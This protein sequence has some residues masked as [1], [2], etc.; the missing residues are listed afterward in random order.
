MVVV[1]EFEYDSGCGCGGA[2]GRMTEETRH[3]DS[4]TTRV[5]EH[6]YDWRGR[7]VTIDGEL[8]YFEKRYYDNLDRVVRVERYDTTEQGNLI[9]RS[10][11]FHDDLGR[12]YQTKR[13]AVD[14]DDGTV[15]N[16]LVSNT[17]YDAVGNAIKQQSAGSQA[18]TKTAYDSL[19]RSVKQYVVYDTD[20]TAYADASS[21]SDDTIVEQEETVYDDTN[22]VL[23]T[24]KRQR[25]HN[26][27]GTGEL[28]SPSGSQPKARVTYQASY[29]DEVGRQIAVAEY[30]T[31]GGAAF[32]RAAVVP[33]R[34]DTILVT[35]MGYDNAGNVYKTTDPAGKEHRTVFDDR[36][37]K[38]KAIQNY[39]DGNPAT[40]SADE[41][42]TVEMTYTADGNMETLTAKNSTT[43]DQTTTYVYGT[44]LSDSGVATSTLK[45]AE[46]YP[47]SD[48]TTALGDGT[49]D[50]YDRIEFKYDRQQ[51]VVEVKD[52]QETVHAFDFDALGRQSQDRVTTLGSGV[53]DSVRRIATEF[54]TLGRKA[55]ITSY[56]NPTVGSGSIV[57]EL[58]FVYDDFGQLVT[59]YQEHGGA[60]NTSTSLK[61]QYAYEDGTDNNVRLT[62]M[63]YPDGRELNYG[64]GS[65]GSTDDALSR[66][67]SLIDDDGSSHLV[68][69]TYLGRNTFVKTDCPEPDLRYDLARGTGDD[70]YDGFDRFGRIVDSRW[71]DY[72]SSADV[73]RIKYGYDRAGNRS[74]R[75][76]M[77]DSNSYHDEVYGYDGVNR[78]TDF[79]RGTIN[80]GKDAISTLKFAQQWS[81]DSTGNWS[82][83]KEDT[84]GDSSWDLNQSRTANKVN[85]ITNI[86]ETS[87]PTW[88]TPTYNRAGN[89]TAIPKPADPAS[90]F[91][92]TYDAWNRLV[93]LEEGANTL[94]EYVYDGAKRRVVKKT[95]S[96]GTLDETRHFY[97]T[98]PQKWQVVEERVESGGAILSDPDRQFVWGLRYIDDLVLRDRDTDSNGTLDERLYALQDANWNV[99]ALADTSGT[100][101]ERYAYSAYGVPRVLA[102]TFTAEAASSCDTEV[103]YA[104]YRYD[105]ESSLMHVRNRVLQPSLGAWGQR[106]PLGYADST[107]MYEYCR[108]HPTVT[109]DP[110]GLICKVDCEA[111]RIACRRRAY[112]QYLDCI[113]DDYDDFMLE[114][115]CTLIRNAKGRMC[116]EQYI[117]CMMF[118]NLGNLALAVGVALVVGGVV[119]TVVTVGGGGLGLAAATAGAA[120][121]VM[122]LVDENGEPCCLA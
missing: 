114:L 59:E 20:E 111:R 54:D 40:G 27:T 34:T 99:T 11:A 92:A 13:Y 60:V 63:T 10:E 19:G 97:Y 52:Q 9:A 118:N 82:G 26:A 43:G 45:R 69:Y 115:Y 65:S 107:S 100:V 64:Y 29:H 91:A 71:Y 1:A 21:V 51:A 56:D 116:N 72:D 49:D 15:G 101:Q 41:D 35:S 48:D 47:D 108:A 122:A 22:N 55:K 58:E 117:L 7:S 33:N 36:A 17:W 42:V 85:E 8:D 62:K 30:G 38:V 77:C 3:V 90:S 119:Y 57:N 24:T 120:L 31:Y 75:E 2:D 44:T 50:V 73:D 23:Q 76:Q 113:G 103:L 106:D 37:R 95:Y 68:D 96:A 25:F 112:H 14:V 94:A 66:V 102:P 46:I 70:P 79:D 109:C 121:I 18:F 104:G 16:A 87:G 5:T 93:K 84:G 67:A 39:V 88:A 78:L 89:M 53:D 105:T 61:V 83:F 32:D 86:T 12:V 98:D 110:F 81:L 6:D 28:T 4:A 74:Y 80:G